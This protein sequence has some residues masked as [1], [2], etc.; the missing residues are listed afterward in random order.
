[1]LLGKLRPT[2]KKH[3]GWV[4]W[5]QAEEES[6]SGPVHARGARGVPGSGGSWDRVAGLPRPREQGEAGAHEDGGY[7]P[8]N[9]TERPWGT[10]AP[11]QWRAAEARGGCL[12]GLEGPGSQRPS[13]RGQPRLHLPLRGDRV[14][15]LKGFCS[16]HPAP[17][18]TERMHH[19]SGA[20]QAKNTVDPGKQPHLTLATPVSQ[21]HCP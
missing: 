15:G 9:V 11:A 5:S 13:A 8:S 4:P 3:C 14:W 21:G 20:G 1:M 18:L 2:E 17:P 12:S 10:R 19:G 7:R 16:R 6:S